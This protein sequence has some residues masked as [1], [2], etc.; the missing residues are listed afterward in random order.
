MEAT[1]HLEERGYGATATPI[2]GG[3]V[4]CGTC[5]HTSP[6]AAVQVDGIHRLEGASDP[7]DMSAVVAIVCPNCGAKAALV[8]QFGPT[9]TAEDADLLVALPD[10]PNA[11]ETP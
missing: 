9:A 11:P 5:D 3:M 2:E 10:P 1:R 8:L 4:C 7:D 6:G